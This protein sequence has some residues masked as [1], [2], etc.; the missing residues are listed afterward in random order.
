MELNTQIWGGD[1][2][3]L[4]FN[5][6]TTVDSP[7][8]V[9]RSSLYTDLGDFVNANVL[10]YNTFPDNSYIYAGQAASVTPWGDMQ[11]YY[12]PFDWVF[13]GGA[14]W[15]DDIIA[16]TPAW[17]NEAAIGYYYYPKNQIAAP[18]FI[19]GISSIIAESPT[20]V[21]NTGYYRWLPDGHAEDDTP[22]NSNAPLRPIVD[23][24]PRFTYG[25]IKVRYFDKQNDNFGDVTL[26]EFK[27]NYTDSS[28]YYIALAYLE[29]MHCVSWTDESNNSYDSA[30]E[31]TFPW[32]IG[33][34]D[35]LI[36]NINGDYLS[37]TAGLSNINSILP[38]A[39][40][41]GTWTVDNNYHY[42][43]VEFDSYNPSVED[44]GYCSKAPVAFS[45][46]V[47][48]L[49]MLAWENYDDR[50]T[51]KLFYQIDNTADNIEYLYHAAAAYGLYFTDG[52]TDLSSNA[53]RWTHDNMCLGL[54][55]DG[56]GYGDYTHG[57]GNIDNPA[58]NWNSSHDSG[59]KQPVLNPIERPDRICV[60]SIYEPQDGY[61]NN[62]EAVLW[63][64]EL[65]SFKE[66][67]G[68]WD[69]ELKHPI[70]PYGKWTY[71]IGQNCIKVNGQIFRIDETEIYTDANQQ[72]IK[73]H[74]NHISFDLKDRFIGDATFTVNGGT[75]YM[76]QVYIESTKLFPTQQPTPYEY[77]F[78]I[79]SDITG[80]L[81]GD[82]HDQ[83]II[84]A[85]YGDDNSFA[86]RYGGE[87]YRDNFHI[88]INSTMENAPVAPAF[89]LRYG[90]DL[91]KI[92]YKIDFSEWI[93]ELLC[94]DN[95]GNILGVSYVGSEW[96]I[97][98]HKTKRLHFTYSPD[99]PDPGACLTK[100]MYNY[101]ATVNTPKVSID[102]TVANLKNDPKYK[103]F[104]DLQ[105][106][107]V[108]YTGNVYFEQFGID[109]NLKI[110]SIRRNE[111]TGEAIQIVLGNSQGSFVKSPVMSQ[112][113]VP[114]SSVS[115]IQA[116]TLQDM[117]TEIETVKLKSMR[118]WGGIKA[119]K[120][121][122]V[123][124]YKWE[125]IKNGNADD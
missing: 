30:D 114:N 67:K 32:S 100:D 91:T 28:R 17:E 88:S 63:P 31:G 65:E 44:V 27:T 118:T 62:G 124:K 61:N 108:G 103:D 109:I 106:L 10:S 107:D 56:V 49:N 12:L 115:A 78:E 101:W 112:T 72:Y 95:F 29:L 45:K 117:Q 38:L 59:Y 105:N 85:F 3:R 21:Y 102:V 23:F 13:G 66:D 71:I 20:G 82:I 110:V 7:Y 119:Y 90:T 87:L 111:L 16:N 94:E 54:L 116:Q 48:T 37:F 11:V 52:K 35:T 89:Q 8:Y 57:A 70:D 84:G 96:I 83:T 58:Y 97:H 120:W 50:R 93:T 5:S 79:V 47:I 26:Y 9:K 22:E 39:G 18:N 19:S 73:A 25:V 76:E 99:T 74:A 121:A 33:C 14:T 1:N 77:T 42:Y 24:H 81:T 43:G 55:R 4:R 40:M 123:Q 113:I 60:Y 34:S 122:D 80:E 51:Y 98:H 2:D 69:I 68:R 15:K 86:N 41:L 36:K 104:V 64:S 53:N 125:E 75:A 46:S 6:W 92:S